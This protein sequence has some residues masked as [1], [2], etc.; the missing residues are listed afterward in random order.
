VGA[1]VGQVS[2]P[3][4][5]AGRCACFDRHAA[6]GA[7][8]GPAPTA[9]GPR[10]RVLAVPPGSPAHIFAAGQ[11]AG[12]EIDAAGPWPAPMARGTRQPPAGPA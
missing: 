6:D 9:S 1:T 2:V 3:R 10:I 8:R 11:A 5:G 12:N 4:S 7:R